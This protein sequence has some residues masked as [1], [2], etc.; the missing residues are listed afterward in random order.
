M[1]ASQIIM[2][3]AS[4]AKEAV[5]LFYDRKT[6]ISLINKDLWFNNQCL[7]TEVIPKYV[8]IRVQTHNRAA[9]KAFEMGRILWVKTEIRNLHDKKQNMYQQLYRLHLEINNNQNEDKHEHYK[10]K[11]QNRLNHILHNK[12]LI[13]EN[14]IDDLINKKNKI[15]ENSRFD[16]NGEH[17][18]FER[19]KN[20]KRYQLT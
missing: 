12:Q 16:W 17:T 11:F 1:M 6:R 8:G 13:L 2:Y 3:N 20:L 14:K 15:Y 5:N 18:L 19:T 10:E 7:L 9:S 4:R